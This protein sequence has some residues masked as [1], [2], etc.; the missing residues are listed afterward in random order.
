[1]SDNYKYILRKASI[2]DI[3]FIVDVIVSAEKGG[4]DKLG[5]ANLFG[6]SEQELRTFLFQMLEEEVDGCEFSISS[7]IVAECNG[8]P[9]SAFAG[10][11]E[12]ANEDGLPSSMLK[13]NLIAYY[14]PA[15]NIK[16]SAENVDAVK[17]LQVDRPLGTYQ[18]EYAYTKPEY[19]GQ[20][21]LGRIIDEHCKMA[22][23]L[24]KTVSKM[25]VHTFANNIPAL[26]LYEKCGFVEVRRFVSSNPLAKAYYP[27]NEVILLEKNI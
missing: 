25:Y 17:D 27:Y 20:N 21:L 10:W 26:K 13:S 22:K 1:M 3:D 23:Q 7:F 2:K 15:E 5:L 24:G 19:R 18:L 11:L 6:L 16:K 8:E 9:V 14:F 12:G 4:T